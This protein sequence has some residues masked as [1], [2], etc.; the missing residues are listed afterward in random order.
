MY[1]YIYIYIYIYIFIYIYILTY[2]EDSASG[3]FIYQQ[4]MRY[5]IA[6]IF[7]RNK[8]LVFVISQYFPVFLYNSRC[9]MRQ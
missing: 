9:Y 7:S 6:L 8:F 1:L 3:I 2:S 4:Q 5:N